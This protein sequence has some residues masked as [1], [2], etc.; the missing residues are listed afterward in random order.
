MTRAIVM[1]LSLAALAAAAGNLIV[2]DSDA[3]TPGGMEFLALTTPV[4][5]S[6]DFFIALSPGDSRTG[7]PRVEVLDSGDIRVE[8]YALVHLSSDEGLLYLAD[9]GEILFQ[10][11]RIALLKLDGPLTDPFA[12]TGV[13]SI[14][15][16]RA[17]RTTRRVIPARTI[18][19][20]LPSGSRTGWIPTA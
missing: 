2:V 3:R 15:P 16:L 5:I 10:R 13:L 8:N 17:V 20:P 6:T 1:L 7:S 4:H 11:D 12:R 14:Q 19:T 18:S 9:L